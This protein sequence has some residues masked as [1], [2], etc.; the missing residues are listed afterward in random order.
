MYLCVEYV[1]VDNSREMSTDNVSK[2]TD[3]PAAAEASARTVQVRVHA[4]LGRFFP[5]EGS[6][7]HLAISDDATVG[8]LLREYGGP[9]EMP[10]V[11]GLNRELGSRESEIQPGDLVELIPPMTGGQ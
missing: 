7:R 3:D 11:I 2:S 5:G 1:F 8:S 6:V 10:L 4:G 9:D